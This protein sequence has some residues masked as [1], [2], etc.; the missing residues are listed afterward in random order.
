MSIMKMIKWSNPSRASLA[1]LYEYICAPSKTNG[2]MLIGT[3]SILSHLT[4]HEMDMVKQ[5]YGKPGKRKWIHAV[6]SLTP[7]EKDRS[8]ESYL[9]VANK[10]AKLIKGFQCFYGVHTD[11]RIRH[12][13]LVFNSVSYLDG[14]KFSQSK[15]DLN[16]LKQGC[17]DIFVYHGFDPIIISANEFWDTEDHSKSTNF[18]FLELE[19]F[20]ASSRVEDYCEE[21]DLP[22]LGSIWQPEIGPYNLGGR[23]MDQAFLGL[24]P[25]LNTQNQPAVSQQYPV[26]T[27]AD[28]PTLTVAPGYIR[29]IEKPD[30][31]PG[32][33]AALVQEIARPNQDAAMMAAN[34]GSAINRQSTANDIP[35][36]M[37]FCPTPII[38]IDRTGY[39]GGENTDKIIE[40]SFAIE[41]DNHD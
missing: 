16:R 33:T 6:V 27:S 7:D 37:I 35:Q 2:G 40:T 4:V 29:I 25:I 38:E 41:D 12:I 13:H 24:S 26:A 22:D 1:E 20:V 11:T 8:S 17:N 5:L 14:H 9:T 21:F 36:N 30:T 18:D 23:A 34:I 19:E 10:I 28:Y 39:D 32:Q 15:A 3:N 31:P